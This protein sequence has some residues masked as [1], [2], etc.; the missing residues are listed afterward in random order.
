MYYF[1][2][3]L[4]ISFICIQQEF[5]FSSVMDDLS[6]DETYL[7]KRRY[8]LINPRLGKR[9]LINPRLG[10]RFQIKDIENLD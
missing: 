6:K 1:K 9:Y 2:I 4:L 7:S 10:K 3:I 8:S 5:I